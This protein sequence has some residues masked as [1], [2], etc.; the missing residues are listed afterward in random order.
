M[1]PVSNLKV[2]LDLTAFAVFG[3]TLLLTMSWIN[4][5]LWWHQRRA[6]EAILIQLLGFAGN[7]TIKKAQQGDTSTDCTHEKMWHFSFHKVK[8]TENKHRPINR[9]ST[10]SPYEMVTQDCEWFLCSGSR[11]LTWLI[12]VMAEWT[13][14]CLITG[15]QT[16]PVTRNISPTE[17]KIGPTK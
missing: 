2:D 9:S 11:G 13:I 17:R 8:D 10:R 5:D 7:K 4:S 6:F 3:E 14:F 1:H 12:W 16:S 15:T